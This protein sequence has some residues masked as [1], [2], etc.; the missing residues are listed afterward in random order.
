MAVVSHFQY[1]KLQ[2]ARKDVVKNWTPGV[3]AA[4]VSRHLGTWRAACRA[5]RQWE[6]IARHEQ[7]A[8]PGLAEG[9]QQNGFAGPYSQGVTKQ[10][11]CLSSNT[12]AEPMVN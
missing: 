1:E 6:A 11:A 2:G 4:M 10:P 12:A 9:Q 3:T 7:S 8:P 5:L